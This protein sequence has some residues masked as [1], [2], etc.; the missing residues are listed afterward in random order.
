VKAKES[1]RLEQKVLKFRSLITSAVLG[2][3]TAMVASLGPIV[4]NLSFTSMPVVSPD[5]L[6]PAAAGMTAM[7]SG[8]LGFFM[9]GRRFYTNVVVSLASFLLVCAI[10]SPLVSIPSITL[11][12]VK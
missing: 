5:A 8:M 10:V 12:G 6:L 4:G 9:S 7:S 1:A 11:W 2:A 3:V